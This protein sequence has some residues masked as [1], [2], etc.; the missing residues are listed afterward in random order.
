MCSVFDIL[1]PVVFVV[2]LN[3]SGQPAVLTT[4]AVQQLEHDTHMIYCGTILT[5]EA[6]ALAMLVHVWFFDGTLLCVPVLAP[7]LLLIPELVCCVF[8]LLL[9]VIIIQWL[10]VFL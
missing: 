4:S 8:C 1:F 6:F 2:S 7:I 3:A 9:P 5:F 10:P